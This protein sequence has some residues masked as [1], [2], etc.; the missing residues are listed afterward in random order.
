MNYKTLRNCQDFAQPPIKVCFLTTYGQLI[1]MSVFW[2][3]RDTCRSKA[4]QEG[5]LSTTRG[6][7]A[8]SWQVIRAWDWW[9][10]NHVTR[11]EAVLS[12][13]LL[14]YYRAISRCDRPILPQLSETRCRKNN[15][16]TQIWFSC[17]H[18]VRRR[19]LE[20]SLCLMP[21]RAACR[22]SSSL[23]QTNG[24]VTLICNELDE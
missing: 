3:P 8:R 5:K 12:V 13:V 20:H 18:R 22:E 17:A 9:Q 16:L 7:R 15:Y 6:W 11:Y 21:Y 4:V 23:L 10:W 14:V 2:F 24:L 19:R 1:F